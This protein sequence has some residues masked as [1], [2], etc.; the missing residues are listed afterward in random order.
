VRA[1]AVRPP[2]QFALAAA[3]VLVA[4]SAVLASRSFALHPDLFRF[5]VILDVCAVIPLLW[6]LLVGRNA[7]STAR[8]A[9]ISVAACALVFGRE[10]RLLGAPLEI[11]LVWWAFKSRSAV[12]RAITA[13]AKMF[14]YAL[15]TWHQKPPEGFTTYKRSGW[16]AIDLAIGIM[17]VAEGIPLHFVLPRGWA[18]ASLALHVYTLLWLLGDLR[19]MQLRP[20]TVSDGM[21]HL[22]IGLKWEADIPL[23]EIESVELTNRAEGRKLAVLGLPNVVLRLGRPHE[24]RGLFGVRRTAQ[25]L[26]LQLDEPTKFGDTLRNYAL[27]K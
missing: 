8:V 12:A 7:R 1:I 26:S 14:W 25:A 11:A 24:V 5:A 9:V 2:V 3:F 27:R 23:G 13:E 20:I 6:W 19:A 16:V 18:I 21:L 4:E 15:F 10:V 17:V 22:Q